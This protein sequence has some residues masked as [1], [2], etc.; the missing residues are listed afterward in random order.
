MKNNLPA[1]NQKYQVDIQD[2]ENAC[3][4]GNLWRTNQPANKMALRNEIQA[5]NA[6]INEESATSLILN[7]PVIGE[8]WSLGRRYKQGI[9]PCDDADHYL[10][11]DNIHPT[12]IGHQVIAAQVRDQIE[13]HMG[14][15]FD[16]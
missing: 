14:L 4:T 9:M 8:A 5:E 3:F 1:F 16:P 11:W 2:T 13:N 7:S 12:R 15:H 6:L 10:F